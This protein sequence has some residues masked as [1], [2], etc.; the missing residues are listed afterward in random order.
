M[1]LTEQ[2]LTC[3]F[4]SLSN[5]RR[6]G[7]DDTLGTLNHITPEKRKAA[8][9]MIML[10]RTVSCARPIATGSEVND[11]AGVAPQRYMIASGEGLEIGRAH[12]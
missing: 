5:W 6:W 4:E 11:Y 1:V 9:A 7:P 12:V 3:Y 8:A 10:G 2:E